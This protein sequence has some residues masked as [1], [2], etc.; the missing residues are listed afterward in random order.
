[1]EC[2]SSNGLFDKHTR[3]D[4]SP[5]G[6]GSG[7]RM[8]QYFINRG[9]KNLSA[10]RRTELERAPRS[11]MEYYRADLASLDEVPRLADE[12]MSAHDR[13]DILINNA[14]FGFG[15]PVAAERSAVTA[16]TSGLRQIR[17]AVSVDAPA[18]SHA[19]R[20]RSIADRQRCINPTG[21]HRLR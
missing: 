8:I 10:R 9:G 4:V 13:L 18:A 7:I 20:E 5:R 2:L 19:A 12:V 6:L 11:H 15:P 21:P 16:M 3:N 17:R 1:M 14:A